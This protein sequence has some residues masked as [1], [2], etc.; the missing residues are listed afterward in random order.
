MQI[1]NGWKKIQIFF[2]HYLQES[3]KIKGLEFANPL[4]RQKKLRNDPQGNWVS[5]IFSGQK[6]CTSQLESNVCRLS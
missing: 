5:L 3:E 6:P 2:F 1:E 4:N